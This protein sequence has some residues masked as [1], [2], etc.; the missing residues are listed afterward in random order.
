MK[1]LSVF[2]YHQLKIAKKTLKM[3]DVGVFILGGMTKKEAKTIIKKLGKGENH[4]S[5]IY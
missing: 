5:S 1:K 4:V 2:D 3:S